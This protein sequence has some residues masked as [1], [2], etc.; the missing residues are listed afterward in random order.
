[1]ERRAEVSTQRFSATVG[2]SSQEASGTDGKDAGLG[3]AALTSSVGSS[4]VQRSVSRTQGVTTHHLVTLILHPQSCEGCEW[5]G[6]AAQLSK[7]GGAL[8][9]QID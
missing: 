2:S 7:D 9:R 1:M 6:S 8:S 3:S 4:S 5:M